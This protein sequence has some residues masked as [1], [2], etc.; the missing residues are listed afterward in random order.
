MLVWQ[1]F[2]A[3]ECLLTSF[4]FLSFFLFLCHL[5]FKPGFDLLCQR[6]SEGESLQTDIEWTCASSRVQ[7][8]AHLAADGS[9]GR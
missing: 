2:P 6:K 4:F 3:S 1:P 5:I 8:S 7:P 9:W